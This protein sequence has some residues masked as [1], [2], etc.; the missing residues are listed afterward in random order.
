MDIK[1]TVDS[2]KK[3]TVKKH[4]YTIDGKDFFALNWTKAHFMYLS[5]RGY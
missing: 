2:T 5:T 3:N 4:K 1:K